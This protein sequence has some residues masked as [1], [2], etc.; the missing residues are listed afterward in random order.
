[1]KSI[2]VTGGLGKSGSN[3]IRYLI[4]NHSEIT[5]IVIIDNMS[6]GEDCEENRKLLFE[7]SA[8]KNVK[9]GFGNFN[10]ENV[11]D[12]FIYDI[13]DKHSIDTVIHFASQ[14]KTDKCTDRDLII[15][16]ILGTQNLL[17]MISKYSKPVHF[18]YVY[19]NMSTDIYN[20]TKYTAN[21]LVEYY[22]NI[23]DVNVTISYSDES[24]ETIVNMINKY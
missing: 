23:L 20:I 22:K 19:D 4:N 15:T 13:F 14:Y 9:V 16:N 6:S 24:N 8:T 17:N 12:E 3:F 1:M 2:I 18:H 11:M 21:Q 5:N 7:E 10:V